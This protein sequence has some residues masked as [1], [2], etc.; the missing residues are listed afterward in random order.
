MACW[1]NQ[2]ANWFSPYCFAMQSTLSNP[3][4]PAPDT[5]SP[6][7]KLPPRMTSPLAVSFLLVD[8]PA[9][10]RTADRTF[11][12]PFALRLPL[13]ETGTK[14]L[15]VTVQRKDK[16]AAQGAGQPIGSS[17]IGEKDQKS[18]GSSAT[19]KSAYRVCGV[20][21]TEALIKLARAGSERFCFQARF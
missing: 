11:R 16:S 14:G 2:F 17:V 9:P 15:N 21:L 13:A 20:F 8:R 4:S 7:Q 5:A 3:P 6:P 10:T 19:K 18:G 12:R 1:K